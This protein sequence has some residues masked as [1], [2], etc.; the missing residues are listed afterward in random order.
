MNVLQGHVFLDTIAPEE[1]YPMSLH[2]IRPS[3]LVVSLSL[4]FPVNLTFITILFSLFTFA[5]ILL[6]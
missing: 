2:P 3:L 6:I 5:F 4:Y 1:Y